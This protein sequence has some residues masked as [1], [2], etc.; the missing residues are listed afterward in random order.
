MN[1]NRFQYL[2]ELAVG[3]K[4]METR[5]EEG[6]ITVGLQ[7]TGLGNWKLTTYFDEL[8]AIYVI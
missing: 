6:Q 8:V 3:I 2:E 5:L 7:P 1:K 4:E